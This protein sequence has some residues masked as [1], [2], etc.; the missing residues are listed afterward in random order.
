MKGFL[1]K[2]NYLMRCSITKLFLPILFLRKMH[3]L[4]PCKDKDCDKYV[5]IIDSEHLNIYSNFLAS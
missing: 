1:L 2:E 3:L 5:T 4:L